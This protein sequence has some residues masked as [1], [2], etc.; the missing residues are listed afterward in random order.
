MNISA[1]IKHL[2]LLM[3]LLMASGCAEQTARR[4]PQQ[5]VTPATGISIEPGSPAVVQQFSALLERAELLLAQRQ[6]LP[7]ASILREIDSSKLDH[8]SAAR[9]LL[10]QTELQ[11]LQGETRQALTALRAQRP[12]LEPL[13]PELQWPLEMRQLQLVLAVDG[14]AAA[15]QQAAE[16]VPN[17]SGAQQQYLVNFCWRNLYRLSQPQLEQQLELSLSG[18]WSAWLELALLS[19]EV[20]DSPAVQVEELDLWRQ[21]HPQHPLATN[22]PGGLEMLAQLEAELVQRLALLLPLGEQSSNTG[23]AVLDGFMAAQYT[24]QANGWPQQQLLILNTAEY[25]NIDSA[26]RAAVAAGAE[27]IVGPLEQQYLPGWQP[28][29]VPLLTLHWLPGEPLVDIPVAQLTIAPEDE[30]RQVARLAFEAG[31]RH[32]LVIRPAG[33]WGESMSAALLEEWQI[34]EGSIQAVAT[35]SG[36]GDYSSSLK[37]AL[38]LAQSEQ[39]ATSIRQLMGGSVEFTPRRRLDLDVVFLLANTPGDARSIKP[40]LAFHYAGDLPVYATSEIFTGV[41]DPQ[42]DRDLNGI[43]L[44]AIPWLD[45]SAQTH[46]GQASESQADPSLA[47]WRALGADA[48]VLHWRLPQLLVDSGNLIRGYSGVLSADSQGRIHRELV[49]TIIA[50]GAPKTL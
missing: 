41:T 1:N 27:L 10:L 39:R 31:A 34:L 47:P 38:N 30:A 20:L 36:Q 13:T 45:S 17:Y 12:L 33:A 15:A 5:P 42:R 6:L 43:R 3:L 7:A 37:T 16:A 11:Y 40:L 50:E 48:Y 18:Q 23:R 49:P 26:Y 14:S 2:S 32:A 44:V 29:S 22:L 24:A 4:G 35:Y 8:V 25:A 28:P 21:R 19:A 9:L 46:P